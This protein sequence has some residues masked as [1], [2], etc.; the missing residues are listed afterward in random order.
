MTPKM[1][2]AAIPYRQQLLAS[3]VRIELVSLVWIAIE[4]SLGMIAAVASGALSTSV[5]S[6]DSGIEL[7]SGIVV[8]MRL[9][10]ETVARERM[11]DW[12]ERT[13]SGIVGFCLLALAG[14]V[15]FSAGQAAAI[16]QTPSFNA[17]A[18]WVALSSSVITPWLAVRKRKLGERLQSPSLIGDAAC[19]MTCALMAWTLLIGLL[20]QWTKIGWWVDPLAAIAI[21]A[22]VIREG[23]ESLSAFTSGTPGHMHSHH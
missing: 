4:A 17:L 10:L 1:T 16:R 8:F 5:F 20:L 18:L 9:V 13:A 7:I 21:L 12:L 3:A 19:S 11:P 6:V 2:D 22:F 14:W 15:A 23:V